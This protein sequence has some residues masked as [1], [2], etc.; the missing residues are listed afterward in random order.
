VP[1]YRI[2]EQVS[3]TLEAHCFGCAMDEFVQGAVPLAEGVPEDRKI[4]ITEGEEPADS[5]EPTEDF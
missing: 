1:T 2:T 5:H 4:Y 3:Y